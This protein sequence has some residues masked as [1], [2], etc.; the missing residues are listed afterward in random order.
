MKDERLVPFKRANKFARGRVPNLG[1]LVGSRRRHTGQDVVAIRTKPDVRFVLAIW[2]SRVVVRDRSD[3]L[4]RGH[5]PHRRF[6]KGNGHDAPIVPGESG[7]I[8]GARAQK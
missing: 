3:Y 2:A 7:V 4:S 8:R 6:A 5:V 1:T